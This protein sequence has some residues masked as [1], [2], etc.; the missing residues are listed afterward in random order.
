MKKTYQI[1]FLLIGLIV[2][3]VL[4]VWLGDIAY[5]AFRLRQAVQTIQSG[6]KEEIEPLVAK[7]LEANQ[8]LQALRRDI[9]PVYPLLSI[10]GDLSQADPLLEFSSGLGQAGSGLAQTFQPVWEKSNTGTFDEQLA[11]A[12]ARY[13]QYQAE[14]EAGL[15]RARLARQ[16]IK[17]EVLPEQYR[18]Y[19]QQ[20]DQ[21]FYLLEYLVEM[22]PAAP[23]LLGME[24]PRT[25]LAVAQNRDELRASG[26]FITALGLVK[27]EKGQIT[28]MDIKDSYAVDDFSKPYPAPPE[29]IQKF[30]LAGYWV[31]RDA[32]W[33]PDFPSSAQKLEELYTLSTNQPVDGVIAFD[34]AALIYLLEALGPLQLVDFPEPIRADNVEVYM[35]QAWSPSPEEGLSQE[36]WKQRKDFIPRLA[37]AIL[38]KLFAQKSSQTI[39]AVSQKMVSAVREGHLL[40]YFNQ[41]QA[42]S[43]LEKSG[44][45]NALRPAL[46]DYLLLVDSNIGFNKVDPIIQREVLYRVDL[47]DP[48]QPHSFIQG[49]YTHPLNEAVECRHEAVYGKVYEDMRRRCYWN[50]WR[51]YRPTGSVLLG[52]ATTPVPGAWLLTKQDWLGTVSTESGEDGLA[53]FA[54]LMVLPTQQSQNWQLDMTLPPSILRKSGKGWVYQL[55]VQKQAGLDNLPFKL[56]VV[57]VKGS[58]LEPVPTGWTPEGK[59]VWN[60]SGKLRETTDF[61]LEF[62]QP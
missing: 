15:E 18:D 56:V 31:P 29:P 38:E 54:G 46:G 12:L 60:W 20:I 39:S 36:W 45:N 44:L 9:G 25:F 1:I 19:Y 11:G 10:M 62:S 41:V 17:P 43:H 21:N 7:A 8:D 24:Q 58:I 61:T 2:L 3:I 26:G 42:Q 47:S 5:R 50:Y 6:S 16:K 30:M 27:V 14:V 48:G 49:T 32:N 57:P 52:S 55:R 13:P 23:W 4:G 35:H 59:T 53:V 51:V 40:M 33:S 28:E 22:L 37:K 34:Q